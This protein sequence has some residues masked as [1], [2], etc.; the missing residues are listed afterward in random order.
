MSPGAVIGKMVT[1]ND[2][3][4]SSLGVYVVTMSRAS[5][6]LQEPVFKDRSPLA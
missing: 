6:H 1:V 5:E 2:Q 3:I 4:D